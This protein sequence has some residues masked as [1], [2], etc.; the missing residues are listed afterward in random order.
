MG[1]LLRAALAAACA[2]GIIG[3]TGT[4]RAADL[5]PSYEP[6]AEAPQADAPAKG[7][8]KDESRGL[9]GPIRLGPLAAVGASSHPVDLEAFLKIAK[10]AGVGFEYAF[11]PKLSFGGVDL[12]TTAI[13]VDA[14]LF[15]FS[16][17]FF[18]GAGA[19]YQT[20][21]AIADGLGSVKATS[22]YVTPR[23]GWLWVLDFG[24]TFGLD[25]GATIPIH[26]KV[27]VQSIVPQSYLQPQ[28]DMANNL[29]RLP[30]PDAKLRL[31]FLF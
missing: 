6:Q 11:A 10:I 19:G 16:G 15:A 2:A 7:V 24:L 29:A 17:A 18:L 25:F 27:A 28:I 30:L 23:L 3:V 14:R 5:S 21:D 4:A 1:R 31:G 26:S 20:A 13:G 8:R 9:L 22:Y 12:R